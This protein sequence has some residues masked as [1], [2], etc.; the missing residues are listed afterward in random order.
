MIELAEHRLTGGE[1]K[2]RLS[3]PRPS[4]WQAAALLYLLVPVWLFLLFFSSYA[5]ALAGCV[6]TGWA[7]SR[8]LR[9]GVQRS[10]SRPI[11]LALLLVAC[12]LV[13]S[14]GM[15]PPLA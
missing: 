11:A 12:V 7:M 1:M 10:L 4:V 6:L 9:D 5:L 8:F 13:A 3:A 14:T 2:T 15:L